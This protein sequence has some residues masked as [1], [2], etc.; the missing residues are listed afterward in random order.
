MTAGLIISFCI[1]LVAKVAI[2]PWVC[3]EPSGPFSIFSPIIVCILYWSLN[4]L[5]ILKINSPLTP[6]ETVLPYG[7]FL[8]TICLLIFWNLVSTLLQLLG[9][10]A[11]T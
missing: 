3:P 11:W 5:D 9:G 4:S 2:E 10:R 6:V 7:L 1:C 8:S